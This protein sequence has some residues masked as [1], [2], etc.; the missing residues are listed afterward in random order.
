MR[1]DDSYIFPD[2]P[3]PETVRAVS[4]TRQ[5]GVSV[6]PYDSF[7][8][9][10]H[11][12]DNQAHVEQNRQRLCQDLELV[13]KPH[14]L[15]QIH[16]CDVVSLDESA[17]VPTADGSFSQE[18]G[19]ACVVLTADCLPV[20]IC[21]RQG[22]EV[23]AVHAGWRGLAGGIIRVAIEKFSSPADQL[24][25]W[26]GPAIGP[27]AFEVGQDVFDAFVSPMPDATQAFQAR[28]GGHWLADLYQLA[29]LQ[30]SQLG[31]DEVYGGEF[32]THS[33][34]SRF[35]SFR[36]DGVTGR[37]ASMIWIEN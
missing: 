7:N 34:P 10:S 23:A 33:E 36:R 26:L 5:H 18:P 32:C 29:R 28:G 25:V 4:T 16:G 12:G 24:M 20:L 30:L 15:D 1:S 11:V 37:M 17:H 19:Q 9:A 35:Y 22:T 13:G 31:V 8:L 6:S 3:A 27:Q 2:W 21:N 14:W